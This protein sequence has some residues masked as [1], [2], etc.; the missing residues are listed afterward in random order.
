MRKVTKKRKYKTIFDMQDTE[1]GPEMK[2]MDLAQQKTNFVNVVSTPAPNYLNFV[3][4]GTSY[5]NRIGSKINMQAVH[6][7]GFVDNI[8]ADGASPGLLRMIVFYDRQPNGQ[9]CLFTD[10]IQ[11][12]TNT[13]V[14]A[15]DGLQGLNI[16]NKD[17]FVIIYDKYMY[18]A[19][20]D[21]GPPVVV[22]ANNTT[23]K[24]GNNEYVFNCYIPLRNL[25]SIFKSS[26][27][28]I[29]DVTTGALGVFFVDSTE[30]G[31]RS[32]TWSSRLCYYDE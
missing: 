20:Y 15:I 27:L 9:P 25:V 1:R 5:W 24:D 32:A 18:A 4:E 12:R 7:R 28:T 3:G 16:D 8:E 19:G 31:R 29:A 26:T 22:Q 11:G 17:R 2:Y 23:G 13:G 10:V 14:G 30:N 6:I 21:A